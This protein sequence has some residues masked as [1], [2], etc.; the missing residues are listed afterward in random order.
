MT[1][2]HAAG[3]GPQGNA[4]VPRPCCHLWL[5]EAEPLCLRC[6]PTPINDDHQCNQPKPIQ[7]M[8][9]RHVLQGH[10]AYVADVALNVAGSLGVTAAGD[11][12]AIAWS[13]ES[14]Q[15]LNVLEGHAAEVSCVVLTQRGRCVRC[16]P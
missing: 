13:L 5:H 14:G 10:M 12:L 2:L 15:N 7:V 3:T 9:C 11:D 16:G 8:A 4:C 1:T 6:S